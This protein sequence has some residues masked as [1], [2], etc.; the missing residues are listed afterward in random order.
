MPPVLPTATLAPRMA[1]RISA[2]T[3][4]LSVLVAVQPPPGTLYISLRRASRS[5]GQ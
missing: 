3:L 2:V 4:R 5:V 1:K